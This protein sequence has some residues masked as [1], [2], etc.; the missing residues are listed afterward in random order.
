[1]KPY[2][3]TVGKDYDSYQQYRVVMDS[4]ASERIRD[5]YIE[6]I[7]QLLQ[8]DYGFMCQN[9]HEPD[10]ETVWSSIFDL[11]SLAIYRA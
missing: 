10:F 5:D 1:M 3:D 9:D 7:K 4:F 6:T 8:G 11:K 2:D